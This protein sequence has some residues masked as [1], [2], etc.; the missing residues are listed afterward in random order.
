MTFEEWW[1]KLSKDGLENKTGVEMC[2]V[3]CHMAWASA[4]RPDPNDSYQPPEYRTKDVVERLRA[5][6]KHSKEFGRANNSP[7]LDEAATEI[8]NLR[9]NNA[10]RIC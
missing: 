6:A 3:L 2:R 5:A 7:L 8:E 1:S 9:L 10:L 4:L